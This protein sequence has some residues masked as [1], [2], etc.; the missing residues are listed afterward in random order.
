VGTLFAPKTRIAL[1]DYDANTRNNAQEYIMVG[2]AVKLFHNMQ[3]F[4]LQN[5]AKET[6]FSGKLLSRMVK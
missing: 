6:V 3:S 1:Q 5:I 2:H 4:D